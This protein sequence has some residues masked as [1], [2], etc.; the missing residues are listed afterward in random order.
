MSGYYPLYATAALK[1]PSQ[2]VGMAKL[3]LYDA[4]ESGFGS[5]EIYDNTFV[6][7][8]AGGGPMGFVTVRDIDGTPT[9]SAT[10]LEFTN[11]TVTDQGSGVARVTIAGS[12]TPT[13]I[14]VDTEAAD[15]SCFPAFFTSKNGDLAPKTNEGLLYNSAT[16]ALTATTFVGA[17]TGTASGNALASHT[18]GNITSAGAIGSTANLPII[19]TTSGVLIAGSFGSSANTFCEGDDSR[20]SDARSPTSHVHGNITNA[21][22]IG[23]TSDL[24]IVTTT[25]GVLTVATFTGTG[26]IFVASVSPDLTGNP[27]ATTQAAT[28]NST[29]IATTAHVKATTSRL[30][31]FKIDT[32]ATGA[33]KLYYPVPFACTITG[34]EL[35]ADAT[36][37]VVIDIWSDSFA[38]YPP[39]V[40]DTITGSAKPTISSANKASSTTLTGWTTALPAGHYLEVNVD[41]VTT[42]TN[43]TLTLTVTRT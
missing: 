16:N 23:S 22:A 30:A 38:N 28:D 21:G 7:I 35:V 39:A 6:G 4:F 34:W 24:P 32:T 19:T 29:R 43:V 11:G 10:T 12:S 42:I 33:K 40:G 9:I 25:S 17:L 1:N 5:I 13:A 20:L 41:S 26:T 3:L 27:T 18:H 31:P 15:V 2:Q 36:G 8:D 37:S 14:T